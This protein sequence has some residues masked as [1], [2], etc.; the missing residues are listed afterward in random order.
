[1]TKIKNHDLP[2]YV[3][4]DRT[5]HGKVVLLFSRTNRA[6]YIRIRQEVGSPEF[7][8]VYAALL[9]GETIAKAAAP[10]KPITKATPDTFRWMCNGYAKSDDFKPRDKA[11]IDAICLQPL[12]T[13][14]PNGPKFADLP[15]SELTLDHL[16]TLRKRK[17]NENARSEKGR[18]LG[19]PEAANSWVRTLKR[20]CKWAVKAKH[21]QANPAADLEKVKNPSKGHK[22]WT[23]EDMAAFYRRHPEGS[24]ARLALE[25]LANIGCAR[26]D[27][28]AL[29]NG[30]IHLDDKG[31]K[32]C[33][34]GRNKNGNE[35]TIPIPQILIDT[36]ASTPKVGIK[37]WLTTEFG[38]PF[39]ANGFGN[40]FRDWCIQAGLTD[41]QKRAHGLRK[42][43]ATRYAEMGAT[44]HQLCAAFGWLTLKEAERYTAEASRRK[45]GAALA[46]LG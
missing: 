9:K 18:R 43:A 8:E 1:M 44:A 23:V 35:C 16:E 17:K 4:R 13:S 10:E 14:N 21:L 36:L 6:P 34:Y 31:R 33:R 19:G 42:T 24:Q 26:V 30:N 20:I 39:T 38:K 7:H 3:R 11:I 37:N 12:K 29:G 46:D 32:V 22:P 25:I 5:R 28:V 45:L 41:A 15:I 27:A 2:P 40:K